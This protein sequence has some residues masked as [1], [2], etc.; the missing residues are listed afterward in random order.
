MYTQA[1]KS[2]MMYPDYVWM[3]H[4]WYNT[5]W[6]KSTESGC[7]F[8]EMKSMLNK[9]IVIDHYPRIN[10]ADKNR[11]NIGEIV[12][13]SYVSSVVNFYSFVPSGRGR[14]LNKAELI[15]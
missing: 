8:G 4:N 9:Q 2:G 10:E 11:P 13:A 1:Y 6:W 5:D 15:D 7:T 14:W 3:L 12:S